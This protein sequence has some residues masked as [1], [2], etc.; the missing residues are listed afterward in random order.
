MPSI[1]P[2]AQNLVKD[3]HVSRADVDALRGA[4]QSGQ[5]SVADVETIAAGGFT[6]LDDEDRLDEDDLVERFLDWDE[7]D[8]RRSKRIVAA[9]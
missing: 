7:L 3:A 9:A 1:S 8:S 2:F 6:L 5:S 4:V